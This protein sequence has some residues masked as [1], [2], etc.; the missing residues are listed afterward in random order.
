MNEWMNEEWH[1]Q[2]LKRFCAE[3]VVLFLD[4]A[5]HLYKR[6]CP[7]VQ[8]AA[9]Q[10]PHRVSGMYPNLLFS[11]LWQDLRR[12]DCPLEPKRYRWTEW[13]ISRPRQRY[14]SVHFFSR[15]QTEGHDDEKRGSS[16]WKEM[17]QSKN[18]DWH[19]L[20]L[21][22]KNLTTSVYVSKQNNPYVAHLIP[23]PACPGARIREGKGLPGLKSKYF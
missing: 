18:E 15:L 10:Q 7:Y 13:M 23:D 5:K 8:R 3:A 17:A 21:V 12:F 4:A 20:H 2:A 14:Y 19:N 22:I 6:V 9:P 11:D 16:E 1:C